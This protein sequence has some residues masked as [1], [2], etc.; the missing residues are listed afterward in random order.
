MYNLV[1]AIAAAPAPFTTIFTSSIFLSA[2]SNALINAAAE[3]IAVPC[4]SSCIKGILS[5]SFSLCSM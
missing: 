4:W 3:M 1:Q 2:N 5:S